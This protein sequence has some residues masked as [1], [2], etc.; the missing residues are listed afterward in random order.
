MQK[1]VTIRDDASFAC[2]F[3]ASRW[4]TVTSN[5]RQLRCRSG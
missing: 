3:Q 4:A 1:A 2:S 5:E